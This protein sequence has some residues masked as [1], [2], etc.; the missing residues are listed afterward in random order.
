MYDGIRQSS[1]FFLKHIKVG[2]YALEKKIETRCK[3]KIL[4]VAKLKLWMKHLAFNEKHMMSPSPTQA[5]PTTISLM[6]PFNA[7]SSEVFSQFH[8]Y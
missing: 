7:H 1:W 5:I 2:K 6:H 3:F 4:R 8:C